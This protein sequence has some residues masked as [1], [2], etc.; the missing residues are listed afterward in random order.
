MNKL[1]SN[2]ILHRGCFDSGRDTNPLVKE[3]IRKNSIIVMLGTGGVGKTTI[4]AALGLAAAQKGLKTA[5]ITVDPAR[6]L[7]EA[8][9]LQRLSA[10]PARLDQRRLRAAGL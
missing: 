5:L 10:Q 2:G 1:R 4:A 8:L 7:R 9:G 6:R 3:L